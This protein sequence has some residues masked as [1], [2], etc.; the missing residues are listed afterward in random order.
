M[1]AIG[2]Y[3]ELE[4]YNESKE[5]HTGAICLNTA[6]NALEYILMV[7]KIKKVFLPY[8]TC[9]V[10]LEPLNKL[11]IPFQFYSVDENLEPIFDF[12]VLQIDDAFLYTNYFG[13]KDSFIK[14]LSLV[15]KQ[16]IVDNAQAFYSKPLQG[17]PT[18]YSVRKFF[19]VSDGAYLYNDE[20]IDII[21]EQDVSFER[22]SHLL[23]RV[24]VSAEA[25]YPFFSANDKS[26]D[27][28]SIKK[29]SNLTKS[30]LNTLDYEGIAN[31]RR[32]NFAFLDNI[33]KKS[34]KFSFQLDTNSVPMVYP[35]WTKDK[36]LRNKLIENKIYTANYWPNVKEWCKEDDLEYQLVNEVV[37]LP[38]DQ[39]YSRQEMELI[40]KKII[41][42]Y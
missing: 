24:D 25:G 10:L 23:I 16:L 19:G 9:E 3:F 34:N 6:R 30:I 42:E 36:N 37:Y 12:T 2:G 38:I 41:Y 21:L 15:C 18:F 39:R 1:K 40:V 4:L 26:L 17:V 33:L 29:M 14:Q 8:F 5:F 7:K 32:D 13:L 20:K 28:Q 11:Q 31:K 27:N 22:M 35:Y